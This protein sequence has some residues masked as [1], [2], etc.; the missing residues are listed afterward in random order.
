MWRRWDAAPLPLSSNC[1]PLNVGMARSN[2]YHPATH[3]PATA[4]TL[5]LMWDVCYTLT[6]GKRS[7]TKK[8]T[9]ITSSSTLTYSST[10]LKYSFIRFLFAKGAFHSQVYFWHQHD[11]E[12]TWSTCNRLSSCSTLSSPTPWFHTLSTTH[13]CKDEHVLKHIQQSSIW[14]KKKKFFY[15][16]RCNFQSMGKVENEKASQC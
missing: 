11:K 5:H 3:T 13:S 10:T 15:S 9:F 16:T 4:H 12:L 7:R 2:R 6:H 1:L 8:L 14:E